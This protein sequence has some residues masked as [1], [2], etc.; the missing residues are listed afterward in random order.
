MFPLTLL[1][2][3][4][5]APSP[6]L[7]QFLITVPPAPPTR[8]ELVAQATA[9]ARDRHLNVDHFLKTIACESNWD[10]QALGDAGQS[11]GLVQIYAPPHPDITIGQAND[12][13]FALQFMANEWSKDRA[14]E[15]SCWTTLFA[16]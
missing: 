7:A 12:P 9:I 10:A 8:E 15:W 4:F 5:L 16:S 13:T 14:Y 6:A 2:V 3:L 1:A 11:H